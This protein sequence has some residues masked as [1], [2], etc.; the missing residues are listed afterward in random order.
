MSN[1]MTEA[2]TDLG[3]VLGP[4]FEDLLGI[5]ACSLDFFSALFRATFRIGFCADI[6]APGA[7]K[8]MFS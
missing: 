7:L 2:S 5:E 3:S 8:T 1:S 6:W 4:Y